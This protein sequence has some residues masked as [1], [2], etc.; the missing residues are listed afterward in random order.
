MS[1]SIQDW[2]TSIP[3]EDLEEL[4]KDILP[5]VQEDWQQYCDPAKAEAVDAVF[6]EVLQ[7]WN[8]TGGKDQ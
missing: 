1:N 8:Q 3:F 7:L 6:A 5:L 2:L 4:A